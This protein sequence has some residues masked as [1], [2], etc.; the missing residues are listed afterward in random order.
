MKFSRS[1]WSPQ[2]AGEASCWMGGPYI[3]TSISEVVYLGESTIPSKLNQNRLH[4]IIPAPVG[5]ARKLGRI[6]HA[7][8]WVDTRQVDLVDEL[9]GRWLVGVLITAVHLQGIDSVLVNAL[10]KN[11]VSYCKCLETRLVNVRG[12]DQG[13]C[14]SSLT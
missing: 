1:M 11:L 6:D 10:P 5:K 14:R 2:E 3:W 9:D 12:E 7:I 13:L 4:S 8:S